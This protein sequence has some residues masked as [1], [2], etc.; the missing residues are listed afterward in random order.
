MN[1]ET[2]NK[3]SH[4]SSISLSIPLQPVVTVGFSDSFASALLKASSR[5]EVRLTELSDLLAFV[6]PEL[7]CGRGYALALCIIF[8]IVLFGGRFIFD[9]SRGCG[10]ILTDILFGIPTRLSLGI[11]SRIGFLF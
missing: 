6:V 4:G 11:R 3:N 10:F 1:R 8:G 5:R 7:G 2:E 9:I